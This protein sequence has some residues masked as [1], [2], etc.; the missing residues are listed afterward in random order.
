[1][2]DKANGK[3]YKDTIILPKTDFGMKANLAQR[4]PEQIARWD[5]MDVYGRIRAER[6]GAPK[7]ILHDGP[8]YATGD[9]HVGTGLNK[10]LKDF[11]VR[12][13]TMAGFDSPYRPGWDCHGLPIEHKV[14]K[15]LGPRARDMA[16]ADI[17][18]LCLDYAMKFFARN[19]DDFKRLSIFGEWDTPYLTVNHD[20]EA[21]VL[22]LFAEMVAGGYVYR[23]L[24][25]IHW[26]ITDRTALAEAELEYDD[27]T[28]PS[29]YVRFPLTD[30]SRARAS[31]LFGAAGDAVDLVIWTTTP[32][33]LPAN[34]AIA[35][36]P[37]FDYALFAA[38]AAD[39]Q[40]FTGIVAEGLLDTLAARGLLA[41]AK[42]LGTCK[43]RD[44]EGLTYRHVFMDRVGPVVLADYV[45]LEGG[46][47]C[48]HTAPGHGREDFETGRRYGLEPVS[49]VDASGRFTDAGGP[50]VGQQ[51]FEADP[52]VVKLLQEK[53]ALLAAAPVKHSYPHCWRCHE[54]VIFRATEQWFVNV[55]HA[56][57]RSRLIGEVDKVDWIPDWGK[58]RIL[59]MVNTRPDWCIS[60]QR[61]WGVPIP[62]FYC[63]GCGQTVLT[64]DSVRHVRDLFAAHGSDHW[65]T[66]EAAELAPP[67]LACPKCGGKTFE[68]ENDIFDVWFESGSSHWSVVRP[69]GRMQWPCDLYLEGS[70]QHRGWFQVSMITAMCARNDAPYQAVLTHGFV[71]DE[72]GEKMS[73]SRGN[74]I[75]TSDAVKA[76]GADIFRLW[77]ASANFR[78]D[79]N[80]SIALMQNAGESYRKVRNTIRFILGNLH[81]FDPS[82]DA[83]APA[84]MLPMD[85]WAVAK[86]AELHREVRGHY[87]AY[88]FH[89]VFGELFT[90]CDT[91]LSA[92]YLDA[93]K[94][95]LYCDGRDSRSR[96]SAQTAIY[97]CLVQLIQLLA[98]I[99]PFTAEEAYAAM[100]HKW[101]QAD[102]VHLLTFAP[103]EGDWV[104]PELIEKF[105]ELFTLRDAALDQLEQLRKSKEIGSGLDA[106]VTLRVAGTELLKD[107][108]SCSE[109]LPGLFGVSEVE[110]AE[111]AKK[112]GAPDEVQVDAAR[113]TSPR[114]DRCWRHL[115]SVGSD[116][117]HPTLCA[118]CAAVV[119]A[120]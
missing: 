54:P 68:K 36:H 4:E 111:V 74:F 44:L 101:A 46:T 17:R 19:R 93:L 61:S 20:Y 39:G 38:A 35:V 45:T 94:D 90:F 33:T 108:R 95:R 86:A 12:Y 114:C 110:I 58:A 1:M 76:V 71:V 67:G 9:L 98:P 104:D 55:E 119:K 18:K 42:K 120:L 3:K 51:V 6:R 88:V 116:T 91:T 60:R 10:V 15:E 85:R 43:G 102:S 13:K 16:T 107:Y 79:I 28:S 64:A 2:S 5:A 80:T 113:S 32:W 21:G 82:A 69:D 24:R 37:E 84:D 109:L 56:D 40:P 70:D 81:D 7:F 112:T 53:G 97:H 50:F 11:V 49:P 31:E 72:K 87:D 77:V 30:E 27:I 92:F 75:S 23:S 52:H 83:V 118:R 99:C 100:P 63:V 29:V 73:K 48:V 89:R 62:A 47:G 57:L 8:P 26:C 41:D 25:P 78:D 105:R 66:H 14:A 103:V 106:R 22:D 115:E 34:L 96:R 117:E 59:G 65:F